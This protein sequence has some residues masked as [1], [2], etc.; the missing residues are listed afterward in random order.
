MPVTTSVPDAQ[1]FFDPGSA[2]VVQSQVEALR[3]FQEA[4]RLDPR[5]AMAHWGQAML[6]PNLNAPLTAENGRLAYE[7]IERARAAASADASGSGRSIDALATRFSASP[8]ADRAA[9]DR[10]CRG[11]GA[12]RPKASVDPDVQT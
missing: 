12:G 11:D 10:L 2:A 5:L 4:A 8:T 7:A 3:A 9:L 6:A 1:R